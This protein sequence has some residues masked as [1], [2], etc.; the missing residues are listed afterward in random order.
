MQT[1]KEYATQI[2]TGLLPLNLVC[3]YNGIISASAGIRGNVANPMLYIWVTFGIMVVS[4]LIFLALRYKQIGLM[5]MFNMMFY[6]VLGLFFLQSVPLVHINFSGVL[7]MMIGYVLAVIA[8]TTSLENAKNEYAR[9]KK[10]HTSVRQGINASAV[11]TITLNVMLAL[12]G[13]VCALMP[14]MAIQSFGIVTMV[15]SLLNIFISQAL[16][17]LMNKLYLT[18]NPEDGKKCNFTKEEVLNND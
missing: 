10:L 14:N 7:A 18:L 1:A 8:L 5:A 3:T 9:G 11:S 2:S 17:R 6:I 15:L 12:A 13:I 4:S 16:M